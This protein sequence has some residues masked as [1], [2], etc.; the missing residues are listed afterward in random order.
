M[1]KQNVSSVRAE[2]IQKNMM[3]RRQILYGGVL[4]T[5]TISFLPNMIRPSFAVSSTENFPKNFA[6]I[7]RM[8]VGR[9]ALND[10][11][12]MRGWTGLVDKFSDFSGRYHALEK[13]IFTS[14]LTSIEVIKTSTL[15]KDPIH[16]QTIMEII[17]AYYLGRIGEIHANSETNKA[18]PV[19]FSQALMWE[20]TI[21]VTVLPTYARGGPGYWHETPQTLT[22]D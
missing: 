5:M 18:Y 22:T 14:K 4:A 20:P 9:H 17:S 7:S 16:K 10:S 1:S 11:V 3:S 19:T 15:F 12:I 6:T 2:T 13:A 8:L 21:D